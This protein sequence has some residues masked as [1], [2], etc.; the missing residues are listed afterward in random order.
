MIKEGYKETSTGL[1]PIEWKVKKLN[2]I[3][4]VYDG[5]HQTPNY[6]EEGIP[7]YSVEHV[8]SNNF[9]TKK[10][11][12]KDVFDKEN[13][14]VKIEQEDILMTRI[15]DV[16]TVKYID[17]DVNA[18]F[19]VSLAL[20]KKSAN[21]NSRYI[22]HFFRG[23]Q[24]QKE[25]WKR[26]IHTAFPK[27]I[28]LGELSNCSVALPP[29][30]E[31]QKIATI[32]STVDAKLENITQQIYTTEQLKKGLMQQLLSGKFNVLENRPYTKEELKDSPLGKIP[33]DWEVV[34]QA[35]VAIFFNGRAYKLK[36]WEEKGTPVIR[37]QN[38]TG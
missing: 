24:F 37:L 4:K 19:Y 9:N 16:G 21:F 33:K 32:L 8:T 13:K 30:P 34:K 5:T 25:L 12:T 2:E 27:K 22:S 15:G 3:T 20:I 23:S 38:L 17:W 26:I 18:S 29:L 11:I 35:E 36:E 6:V 1:T 31:Q 7:F 28:N 14:R 10:F